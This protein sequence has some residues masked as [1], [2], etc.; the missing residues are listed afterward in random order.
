LPAGRLRLN[1]GQT[2]VCP[3]IFQF[4]GAPQACLWQCTLTSPN[5]VDFIGAQP[6]TLAAGQSKHVTI[7]SKWVGRV[8]NKVAKCGAK[9]ENCTVTEFNLDSG[10]FYTP[11]SYDIS[12]I[13]GFTQSIQIKSAGCET[14]TCKQ[15]S[16]PCKQAYPVGDISGCGN[17]SPVR[18]CGAGDKTF[19][20]TFCPA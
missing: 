20:V 9:G 7:P 15:Q 6:G 16:C 17:D 12:N 19:T 3:Q 1:R 8:F 2:V 5:A 11:Q 18:G 10:D 14:V 4:T 13:Q